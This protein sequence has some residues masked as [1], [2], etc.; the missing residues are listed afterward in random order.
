MGW[1][2]NTIG[3]NITMMSSGA[4]TSRWQFCAPLAESTATTTIMGDVIVT[5]GQLSTNGTSNGN[6]TIVVNHYGNV[7]VTGGNFSVGRG[8]QGGTGTARWYMHTGDFTMSNATTQNSNATGARLVFT[9][10]GT[11]LMTLTNVTFGSGGMPAIV[12]SGTTLDAGSSIIRGSGTFTLE[13]DATLAIGHFGGLDSLLQNT[14]TKTLSPASGYIFNGA[15]PQATGLTL[16]AVAGDLTINNATGVA[17]SDTLRVDS[18]L[19]FTAGILSTGVNVLELGPNGTSGRTSG[20]VNGQLVKTMAAGAA[21]KTFEIGDASVYAPVDVTGAV[22]AGAF[23]INAGTTAGDHGGIGS[24]GLLSGQSVNRVYRLTGTPTGPSDITLH[25]D[26]ADLDGGANPPD[27]RVGKYDGAW[28]LPLIGI[29]TATSTQ[30]TG[31]ASL[32]EF[33]IAEAPPTTIS[34]NGTGG[35]DWSLTGTWQGGVVPTSADSAIV[36][37]GDSVYVLAGG[38]AAVGV[39]VEASG[40]VALTDT[41]SAVYST[42]FGKVVSHIGGRFNIDSGAVFAAGGVYQHNQNGGSLPIAT[43]DSASTILFTGV[44]GSSPSNGR[45]NFYDVVWNN[46]A[47]TANLNLGWNGNTIGGD[48]TILS[49]GTGRW[50][51]C[52]PLTDS[53][54]SVTLMGD[55]IMSAGQFT[56]NGTSNGNTTIVVNHYGDI[57]VTGGNFSISRGSQGG[58]GTARWYLHDGDFTMSDATT[59]NS[60]ATGGRFVFTKPGTQTLTLTNVTFGGGGMPAIVESGA[61]LDAG[62]SMIRGSGAFTLEADAT[63][64]T[65][66]FGGLDSTLAGTGTVLLDTLASYVFNGVV[67]QVTGVRMPNKS[68]DLAFDNPAGVAL[69]NF[70]VVTGSLELESGV[71]ST[72][73]NYVAVGPGGTTSRTAGHVNGTLRKIIGPGADSETFEIGDA[74]VYAPVDVAGGSY[75]L[76]FQ[77]EASTAPG[78]HANITSSVFDSALSVNRTWSFNGAPTGTSDVTFHFAAG[79]VDGG[80]NTSDFRVS[81][82]NGS[83]TLLGAGAVTATSTQATGVT[84]FSDFQVGEQHAAFLAEYRGFTPVELAFDVDSKGKVGKYEKR[85]PWR[86]DFSVYFVVDST[87]VNDFHVEFGLAIDTAFPFFSTPAA[88]FSNP[89]GKFKKWDLT[90]GDSLNAGDTVVISGFG[91]AGKPQKIMKYWWTRNGLLVGKKVKGGVFT[92][93][94]P[95]YPMPNRNNVAYE[96]FGTGGFVSTNGLTVGVPRADSAKQYGWL[97]IQKYGNVFKTLNHKGFIHSAQPRGLDYWLK[98]NKPVVKL[99][100]LLEPHKYNNALVA[101]LV[102]LKLGITASMLGITPPGFGELI[103]DGDSVETSP[104]KGY[105]VAEIAAEADTL[106]MGWYDSAGVRGFADTATYDAMFD[107]VSRI[108]AAF[109]GP[110]DTVDGGFTGFLTLTGTRSVMDVYHTLRPNIGVIPATIVPIAVVDYAAV[111]E[112]FTLQQ[113][114]PNPFNPTTTIEFEL[115]QSSLVTL[116]VYNLLGQEIATLFDR[117]ELTDG[118]QDVEFDAT[119]LPSGVYIY[120]LIADGIADEDEGT[121]AQSFVSVKKMVLVK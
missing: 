22:Y 32:S 61:H 1:N 41:L 112:S 34:S 49:T 98:N 106:M 77:L 70:V 108:N 102:A 56:T 58:T 91:K 86:V 116:K 10:T 50:Q 14:G 69:T 35:G 63:L 59:Q 97:Q 2:G 33:I 39:Q 53:S 92:L 90:F 94:Q 104:W 46:T 18:T 38:G 110:V 24:S 3:G 31:I 99:Q 37:G 13:A 44:T 113:N 6:T 96:A 11:Q 12:E 17:L 47:Q 85:K 118:Q 84:G 73:P 66:H 26:P 30:A 42:V 65:A 19:T 82:Y 7:N 20:H 5:G 78:D 107:A 51:M 67:P 52:A 80:A 74:T 40:I 76:A 29:R 100:K 75:G 48:I 72:G 95:K 45:Q 64:K 109:E 88:A 8:G 57:V 62:T 121:S 114:Y 89:D 25:F 16:P 71:V 83:W 23:T 115:P 68:A 55:V 43:W 117:E 27:F 101:E 105:T 60:N 120:R 54:A 4:G 79:D 87:N 81:R 21:S 28:T 103:L 9:K 15:A 93:N 119:N 36:L 111:P